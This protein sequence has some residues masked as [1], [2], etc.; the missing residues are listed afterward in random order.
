[1]IGFTFGVGRPFAKGFH[2]VEALARKRI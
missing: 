2:G 1:M